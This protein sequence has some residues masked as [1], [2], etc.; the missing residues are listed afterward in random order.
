[1]KITESFNELISKI[2]FNIKRINKLEYIRTLYEYMTAKDINSL[3]SKQADKDLR[4]TISY[5]IKFG[6]ITIALGIGLFVVWGGI[7]PLDSASIAEGTI[8]V[9]G[10]H[11]TIQHLEGGVIQ[12]IYVKDGQTVKENDVLIRLNDS[13]TKAQLKIY[14]SQL[15]FALAVQARLSA[16]RHNEAKIA[17]D[18]KIFDPNDSEIKEILQTQE[19][20]FRYRQEEFKANLAIFNERLTQ[21]QEEI[22]GFEAR[23]VSYQSQSKLI[24]E[25]LKNTEILLK[26]GLALRPRLLELRRHL[27]ELTA[28][29]AETKTK[30]SAAKQSIA[31]NNLRLINL[32]NEYQKELAKE[33][34]ENHSQVLDLTEKY[35][36][37]E[38]VLKRVEIKAPTAGIVT[39]LQYHT[40]GGVITSGHKILDIV[41]QGENLIVE[42][43][44]KTQD[45]DS[46]HPGLVA[47]IQLGAYKSRL[48]P[49]LD[50][51]IIYI[52]ADKFTDQH[53]G[54][55]YYI[56]KI[57]IDEKQLSD[58]NVNVKLYPGMP[59]TVFIVKGTRTFLNYLISPIRDSF[60]KAFK[61]V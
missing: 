52:S 54:N 19:N 44:V 39:D 3:F 24:N 20:L 13:S 25:E 22:I 40:I 38:D 35:T 17:W 41:P 59:V 26:K 42:A 60:F 1:M 37:A 10:Y 48:V 50:G 45:I 57:E 9:A 16:E 2:I 55:S 32:E 23:K 47:K 61:E 33:M 11:K 12:D 56:A 36:A 53:Y 6:F 8:T 31:E 15:K 7:A 34:K 18:Y 30:I 43:K 5:P 58:L 21:N 14:T 28:G 49:R 51:K 46:I 27:D 4:Q 29:L